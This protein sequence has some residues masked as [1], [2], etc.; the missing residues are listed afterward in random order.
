MDAAK[1]EYR[2]VTQIKALIA[3]HSGYCYSGPTLAWAYKYV[4]KK[5]NMRVILI[6]PCHYIHLK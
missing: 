6:G 3:P 1:K 2:E 4:A 5:K